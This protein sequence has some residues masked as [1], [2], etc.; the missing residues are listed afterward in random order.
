M[1]GTLPPCTHAQVRP[2]Q[3]KSFQRGGA[4]L[5]WELPMES[6]LFEGRA[7]FVHDS[8]YNMQCQTPFPAS[9]CRQ[10]CDV[11]CD[12]FFRLCRGAQ[13]LRREAPQQ[14]GSAAQQAMFLFAQAILGSMPLM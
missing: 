4:P 11:H 2:K 8:E 5:L 7:C 6:R 1:W 9:T 13:P 10:C 3:A 12:G 14:E